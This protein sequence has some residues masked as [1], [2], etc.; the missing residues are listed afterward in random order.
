MTEKDIRMYIIINNS[1]KMGKGKAVAQAGHAISQVTEIMV[2]KFKKEWREY[3]NNYH[4]KICLKADNEIFQSLVEKYDI[5]N[6]LHI[7]DG[8]WAAVQIDAGFT[9]VPA[10]SATALAF[11]PMKKDDMPKELLS[12]INNLKLF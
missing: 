9:Q 2:T 3:S 11:C 1:L 4:P 10:G 6:G 7:L 8:H 12:I 5:N